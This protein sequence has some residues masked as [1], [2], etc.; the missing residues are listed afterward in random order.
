MARIV[1][2]NIRKSDDSPVEGA[3]VTAYDSDLTSSDDFMG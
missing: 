1:F 3:R 2:G